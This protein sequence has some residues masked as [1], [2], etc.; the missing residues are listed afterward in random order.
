MS[1]ILYRAYTLLTGGLFMSCLP[2]FWL[3]A[4]LSG[5]HRKG[6][7]ERLGVVPGASIRLLS[8]SPRIWLHAVSLGEVR[9]AASIVKAL[10]GIMPRCS[11]ILSTTTP[12]G[13][14]FA[15]ETL[16][17]EVPVVFGPIDFVGSVRK[18]LSCVRP[19]ALVL[20]ETEIW[21]VW[22][23]EAQRMGIKTALVNGRISARSIGRYLKF[24]PFFKEVLKDVDAFSMIMEQDAARIRAMG[25]D[26]EKIEVNGNAKYGLLGSL[27]DPAMEREMEGELNLQ[28]SSRVFVAGSTRQGEEALVLK[29]YEDI[30][31]A[32]PDTILII[33]PRHI[34]RT[35]DIAGL[36]EGRGFKYQLRSEIGREGAGRTAQVV[37]MDTFGEL[38][39]CY[40][41]GTIVFC[42]AS[43]VPL[44]G[45]NPLEAAV[46]GKPV[47]FGPS[48]ENFL[49]AKAL[50]EAAGA[51]ITVKDPEE[52][53]EKA[54]WFLVHP[55]A[56]EQSGARG[57]EAVLNSPN[58]AEKHAEVIRR[59]VLA[60]NRQ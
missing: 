37:I 57:R 12:H 21:P 15:E 43:L 1:D 28:A 41:V 51:G 33:A 59:L 49:D 54:I 52:L 7:K 22:L 60:D 2:P 23:K 47:F 24:R 29:A 39:K 58:A 10:R 20:L 56:L 26:P 6:L 48:M 32:F 44:G 5:R 25:A 17:D 46:W 16:G 40:S 53:A 27:A 50:L 30:L 11:V 34:V 36:L 45:Q 42:G 4:Q 9:V 14:D 8:G 19:D 55:D 18:A 35:G 13:R 3:Y 31:R 38:F